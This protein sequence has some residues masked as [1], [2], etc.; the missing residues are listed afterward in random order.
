MNY[1]NYH[2]GFLL[3]GEIYILVAPT[4]LFF[5]LSDGQPFLPIKEL[6]LLFFLFSLKKVWDAGD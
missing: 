4:G 2:F 5:F 3:Y 6:L 1:C